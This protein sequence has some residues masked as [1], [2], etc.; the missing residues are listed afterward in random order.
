MA[1]NRPRQDGAED[2]LGRVYID[3]PEHMTLARRIAMRLS[4]HS[5]YHP[6]SDDDANGDAAAARSIDDGG[7]ALPQLDGAWSYF[8]HFVLPRHFVPREG[9]PTSGK[10]VR[11]K[12]EPGESSAET[13]LY[14]IWSTPEKD[15][16]D[17][18]VGIGI[19]F[20]TLRC[21]AI[22]LLLAG[23]LNIPNLMFYNSDLYNHDEEGGVPNVLQRSAI[24]TDHHWAACPTCSRDDWDYFPRTFDRYAE[25]EDGQLKFIKTNLCH[26]G[27]W[28]GF[29]NWLSIV[30]IAIALYVVCFHIIKRREVA[31]DEEEQTSSDYS[32]AVE[33]PP[34]DAHDA[35]KW[36][37]FFSQF[38]HVTC[39]TIAIDNEELVRALI[40]RRS[41]MFQLQQLLPPGVKFDKFN[42]DQM[43]DVAL[44]LKWFQIITMSSNAEQL[45]SQISELDEKIAELSK[46]KFN[47][48]EIFVTFETE[49]AQR[50]A[51]ERLC[52]RR[53]DTLT[54]KSSALPKDLSYDG[55]HLLNIVEPPEPSAVRWQDLDDSLKKRL[56][57]RFFTSCITGILIICG[58]MLIT[59]FRYA[60]GPAMAALA[61]SALNTAAPMI[62][63]TLTEY[64][65]HRSEDDK[66][67]SRYGKITMSMLAFTALVTAII[68]PFTD[69]VSNSSDS[70]LYALYAIFVFELIRGPI[71]QCA[72]I[73]GN[74]QR[75][76]LGPRVTNRLKLAGLFAGTP[77]ELSERYTNLT[78]VLFLTFY[79]ATIF[80]A[81][82]FFASLTMATHYMTDKYCLLRIW[83]PSPKIGTKLSKFCRVFIMISLVVL[84]LVSSYYVAGFPFDNACEGDQVP[85]EYVGDFN[86]I[87]GDGNKISVSID[88]NENTFYYCDM[89]MQRYRPPVFPAW[90]SNQPEGKEWMDQDQ[91]NISWLF[92]W[93]SIATVGLVGLIFLN[94]VLFKYF[95]Y[96]FVGHYKP[97]GNPSDLGFSDVKEIFAYVPQVRVPGLPMPTLICNINNIDRELIGW[98]DPMNGVNAHNVLYDIREI[99]EK[100][101]FS[102]IYHWPPEGKR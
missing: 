26:F 42:L 50:L 8:E 102:E 66:Q 30:F 100:K 38:G 53:W 64:E 96:M 33:N 86:A 6:R 40:E 51:L 61:I 39:L 69:T 5:W 68:T 45:R 95:R 77:Y 101:L 13:R 25:T 9:Q 91:E 36:K 22:V 67:A 94:R 55:K 84:A 56:A 59:Y 37:D 21:L 17:M 23:C 29:W 4:R 87:D 82:F 72:D 58:M 90:A 79:Y 62:C 11:Q 47:V 88:A 73:S 44:P 7:S 81:G 83:A 89:D 24:C 14:D 31:Y 16:A 71:T 34:K 70:I 19:Y 57:I 12:A 99:S 10:D 78:N 85:S 92:G 52:V 80:P 63:Y 1:N 18:G 97:T 15:L 93:T 20:F 41:L 27:Y 48:A 35:E 54:N 49:A 98:N 75:H 32:I 3:R 74:I 60:Y 65:S 46:A 28:L 2:D 76:L 43:V